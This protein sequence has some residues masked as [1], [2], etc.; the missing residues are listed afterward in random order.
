[1]EAA[2]ENG[3]C[4]IRAERLSRCFDSVKSS[5]IEFGSSDGSLAVATSFIGVTWIFEPS[6]NGLPQ[7]FDTPSSKRPQPAAPCGPFTFPQHDAR[8][9]K[10]VDSG[11]PDESERARREHHQRPPNGVT[12]ANVNKPTPFRISL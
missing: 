12:V 2:G 5:R 11:T 3:S 6:S 7:L 8:S 10:Y 1:M 4:A 9:P